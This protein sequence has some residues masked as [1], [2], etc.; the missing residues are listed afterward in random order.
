VCCPISLTLCT[1]QTR[2]AGVASL[3]ALAALSPCGANDVEA[4][5]WT[6]AA[7]GGAAA[8]AAAKAAAASASS[9]AASAANAKK[10]EKPAGKGAAASAGASAS[11]ASAAASSVGE[12]AKDATSWA[13]SF[14]H[15]R[16]A[17]SEDEA[18][19]HWA[20]LRA[21]AARHEAKLRAVSGHRYAS[22][23]DES[24]KQKL[25]TKQT[26][27]EFFIDR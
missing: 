20:L 12:E 14:A 23:V 5:W 10:D 21:M 24:K 16:K 19:M 27:I 17:T 7:L 2:A 18:A 4:L 3:L 15:I 6:E 8:V 13:H 11:S 25:P 9:S 26:C 22:T 1:A